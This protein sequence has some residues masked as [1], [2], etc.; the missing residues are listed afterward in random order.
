MINEHACKFYNKHPCKNHK[1]QID[2]RINDKICLKKNGL[3][4]VYEQDAHGQI[5]HKYLEGELEPDQ[6]A[7]VMEVTLMSQTLKE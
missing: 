7:D 6:A 3:V 5:D 1:N 4:M 2:L